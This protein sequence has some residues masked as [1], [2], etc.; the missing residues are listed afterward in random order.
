[1]HRPLPAPTIPP[2]PATRPSKSRMP[3]PKPP[4]HLQDARLGDDE[5]AGQ[6]GRTHARAPISHA[7]Q[8]AAQPLATSRSRSGAGTSTRAAA[9]AITFRAARPLV[10]LGANINDK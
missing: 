6:G 5:V 9:Y 2:V 8:S 4:R 10:R 1:M 3:R 7:S